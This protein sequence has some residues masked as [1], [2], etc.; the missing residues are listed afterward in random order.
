MDPLICM[1]LN[2]PLCLFVNPHIKQS[3]LFLL[4]PSLGLLRC[5]DEKVACPEAW[6]AT[7]KVNQPPRAYQSF[8]VLAV[9]DI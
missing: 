2:K 7:M 3:E 6:E 8:S 1:L 5:F 9:R 4:I